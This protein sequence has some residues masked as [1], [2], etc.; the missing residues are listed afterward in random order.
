MK[1]NI[2]KYKYTKNFLLSKNR[3]IKKNPPNDNQ[4]KIKKPKYKRFSILLI[5]SI[6][7]S[8][9]TLIDCSKNEIILNI[10]GQGNQTFINNTFVKDF[11]KLILNGKELDYITE[12]VIYC[13]NETNIISIIFKKP[14]IT[15]K[16][17]FID[18]KNII[19]IDLSNYDFSSITNMDSMFNGCSNLIKINFTGVNTI[20]V[21]TM[22][23]LFQGCS[24]LENLDLSSLRTNNVT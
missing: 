21:T 18:L 8:L 10:N 20:N 22:N 5:I 7:I 15:C 14:L 2:N 1:V 4:K 12:N 9:L 24:S 19:E 11:K 23:S 17:M 16:Q 6:F 13:S 3:A